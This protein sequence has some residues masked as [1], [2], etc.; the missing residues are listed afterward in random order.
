MTA[1]FI[2]EF[3]PNPAFQVLVVASVAIAL[4]NHKFAAR[5][6]QSMLRGFARQILPKTSKAWAFTLPNVLFCA[7]MLC[8]LANIIISPIQSHSLRYDTLPVL[9]GSLLALIVLPS[10]HS[11]ATKLGAWLDSRPKST[12]RLFISAVLSG[13]LLIQVNIATSIYLFPLWDPGIVL[14]NAFGL[15]D[16]SLT[17]LDADYFAKYPNNITLALLLAAFSHFMFFLGATNLLLTSVLL[18]IAVLLSGILL[19]YLVARRLAGTG[20]AILSLL[21]LGV[22]VVVSPWLTVPY[23]DTFG[24]LF[25]VLL[26][27]LY[28]RARASNQRW[29]RLGLW[30]AI[31]VVGAVGCS[32]KP[33]VVFVLAGISAVTL[34]AAVG[35]RS[36]RGVLASAIGS[37]ILL[38]SVFVIGNSALTYIESSTRVIPFD[39]KENSQAVPLTHFLK[40]GAKGYGGYNAEDAMDT[41]AIENPHERFS[42]GLDGY[43]QRVEAMGPLGYVDFLR[44]KAVW[45]FGDGTFF[46]WS[47]G[48]VAAEEDPFLS[49]DPASRIVQSYLWVKGENFPIVTVIWQSMWFVVLFLVALPVV[50]RGGKLFSQ[51]ATVMRVSLIGLFVFLMLFETRSRYLFLYLPFFIL[52][53]VLTMDAVMSKL[54]TNPAVV[55]AQRGVEHLP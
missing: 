9:L 41:V 18:N 15:A 40:M 35:R 11:A 51:P 43:R 3:I 25:P 37:V 4:W 20:A 17:T 26:F 52:L 29:S 44:R 30:A 22:F 32:I 5:F 24:F 38:A 6:Y 47:E 10:L 7:I 28:L 1:L 34:A 36:M 39:V 55:R 48:F 54:Q 45:T 23:S 42:S 13:F 12:H 2:P 53:L 50:L 14:F 46:I 31:G 21:P 8:L 49:K 16:G 33:T 27:Y 19:T